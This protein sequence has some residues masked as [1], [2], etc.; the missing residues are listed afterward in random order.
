MPELT[1][2][3]VA[4]RTADSVIPHPKLFHPS[5]GVTAGLPAAAG[6]AD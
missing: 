6:A 3:S 4:C 2:A 1:I 5:G